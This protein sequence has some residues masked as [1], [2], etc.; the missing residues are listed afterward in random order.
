ML[1]ALMG[2]TAWAS[3]AAAAEAR[4]DVYCEASAMTEPCACRARPARRG[5]SEK[6]ITVPLHI[7]TVL[8]RLL[9]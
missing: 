6:D 4:R 2:T 5:D 7:R 8:K 1:L 3:A 9:Y